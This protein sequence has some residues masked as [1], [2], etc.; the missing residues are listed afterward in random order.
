MNTRAGAKALA[1]PLRNLK[2]VGEML[3][4][5]SCVTAHLTRLGSDEIRPTAYSSNAQMQR[6]RLSSNEHADGRGKRYLLSPVRRG[7]YRF[8]L[9]PRPYLPEQR[10]AVKDAFQL[11]ASSAGFREAIKESSE[12]GVP[13]VRIQRNCR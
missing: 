10:A 6:S 4:N 9:S 5:F 12:E 2:G 8:P 3:A 13:A 7:K 1:P 11:V